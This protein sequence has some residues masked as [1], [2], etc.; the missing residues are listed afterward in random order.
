MENL[1]LPVVTIVKTEETLIGHGYSNLDS[2]A[3]K[4]ITLDLRTTRV[5]VFTRLSF[6]IAYY[7]IRPKVQLDAVGVSLKLFH[8]L[9]TD[10]EIRFVRLTPTSLLMRLLFTIW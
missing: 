3:V 2:K 9:Q 1:T 7:G 4:L 5:F 8:E 10:C 6:G